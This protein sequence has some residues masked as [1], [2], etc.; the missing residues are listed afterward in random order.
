[1]ELVWIYVLMAGLSLK[2]ADD[3]KRVRDDLNRLDF[4]HVEWADYLRTAILNKGPHTN[5]VEIR[6]PENKEEYQPSANVAVGRVV[7]SGR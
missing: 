2:S 7:N 5:V 6:Y 3:I 1:M 4:S